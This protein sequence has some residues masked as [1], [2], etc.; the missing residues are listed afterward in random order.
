MQHIKITTKFDITHTNVT[1]N[2]NEKLL[3]VKINGHLIES[4]EDWQKRRRQQSNWET[5][6]QVISLRTQPLNIK[7]YKKDDDWVL[8]FDID[9]D[10]V[11]AKDG[12]KLRLLKDDCEHVPMIIELDEIDN[13]GTVLTLDGPGQ[14]IEFDISDY[15]KL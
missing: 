9:F 14:N 11:F 2:V 5:L 6:I 15:D 3:P 10:L 1:R 7:S 4:V 13:I 12:D 8:E